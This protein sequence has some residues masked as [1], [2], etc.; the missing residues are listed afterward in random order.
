M[1]SVKHVSECKFTAILRTKD[2]NFYEEIDLREK[3]DSF[4]VNR[5]N[6]NILLRKFNE[7]MIIREI[8]PV[9][10]PIVNIEF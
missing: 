9:I 1:L 6:V 7:N 2:G 10:C 4:D 3:D 8:S 5:A